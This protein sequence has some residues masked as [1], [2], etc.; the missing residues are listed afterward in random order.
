MV[1]AHAVGAEPLA[2]RVRDPLRGTPRVDE[3]QR[4]PVRADEGRQSVVDLPPLLVRGDGL[5]IGRRHLDGQ[6]EVAPVP[7]VDDRAR[8]ARPREEA[9]GLADGVHGGREPD[10]L[11][12]P[13]GHGIEARERV[14]QVTPALVAHEGVELVDDDGADAPEERARTLGREH[15]VERLRRRDQ[16]VRRASDDGRA[17]GR[18]GVARAEGGPDGR[19]LVPERGRFVADARE[20]RFEVPAGC[21]C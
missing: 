4:R 11:R 21:R 7:E 13:L 1:G 19:R 5:Q 2:E 10:T 6:V 14:A 3:D 9:R 15:Q 20:R 12:A 16:D 18:R 17:F 8:R